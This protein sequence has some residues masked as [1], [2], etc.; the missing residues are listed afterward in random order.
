MATNLTIKEFRGALK[1]LLKEASIEHRLCDDNSFEF[2]FSDQ[3][4]FT[5]K[6]FQGTGKQKYIA[7]YLVHMV[8][9]ITFHVNQ[10]RLGGHEHIKDEL[11]SNTTPE[12]VFKKIIST[13]EIVEGF[14]SQLKG[15]FNESK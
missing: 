5:I 6:I 15:L 12:Q 11:L 3:F 7:Y 13:K 1:N 10:L 9:P 2:L 8:R 14:Q 4:Q